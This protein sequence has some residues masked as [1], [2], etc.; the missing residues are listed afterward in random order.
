MCDIR[1]TEKNIFYFWNKYSSDKSLYVV[2][3]VNTVGVM[4]KGLAKKFKENSSS[5]FL[6]Y[7]EAIKN[8]EL[9][10]GKVFIDEENKI[11]AFPTKKHWKGKSKIEYIKNGLIDLREEAEK[12]NI[13]IIILPKLGSGLGGLDYEKDVR[14]LIIKTFKDSRVKKVVI[15]IWPIKK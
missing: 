8:K 11:I 2:N 6:A 10:V 7:K 3:P 14:P 13:K 15:S 1:K 9:R 12:R 4:G 5:H